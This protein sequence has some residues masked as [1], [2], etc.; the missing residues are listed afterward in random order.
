[1]LWRKVI[2]QGIDNSVVIS[3]D[4]HNNRDEGLVHKPTGDI[5][6]MLE[7]FRRMMNQNE[8]DHS[9]GQ[10]ETRGYLDCVV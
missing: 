10:E 1:M 9:G 4:C 2:I 6:E 5:D 8:N 3:D 7:I